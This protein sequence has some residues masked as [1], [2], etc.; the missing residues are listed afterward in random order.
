MTLLLHHKLTPKLLK[1]RE[2]EESRR[3]PMR[4]SMLRKKMILLALVT[5]LT[6][7]KQ[8]IYGMSQTQQSK[9]K[10]QMYLPVETTAMLY[11]LLMNLRVINSTLGVWVAAMFLELEMKRM[12]IDPTRFTLR[13]L[14]SSQQLIWVLVLNMLLFSLQ[15]I[16]R[17]KYSLNL[18]KKS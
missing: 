17:A 14:K 11:K 7:K 6:H 3:K 16:Q 10:F 8:L 4:K 2:L 9:S 5:L 15:T 1:R 13:C 12:S 18:I